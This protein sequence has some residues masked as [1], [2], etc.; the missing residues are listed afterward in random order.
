MA[1]S[2][3]ALARSVHGNT[4]EIFGELPR[5]P[6]RVRNTSQHS[7]GRCWPINSV[8]EH[9]WWL[10]PIKWRFLKYCVFTVSYTRGI[11]VFFVL[12][13]WSCC[14]QCKCS[15]F[16]NLPGSTILARFLLPGEA[17]S[18]GWSWCSSPSN[19][20]QDGPTGMGVTKKLRV[21]MKT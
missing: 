17:W 9:R 18:S 6:T 16:L 15:T 3:Q 5:P 11:T 1:A 13:D 7:G 8:H 21:V 12:F 19:G 2:I 20:L 14:L 4:S 10:L